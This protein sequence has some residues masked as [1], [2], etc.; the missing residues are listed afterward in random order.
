[1]QKEDEST[2]AKLKLLAKFLSRGR[3]LIISTKGTF[4]EDGKTVT[5]WD[6]QEKQVENPFR[7][8]EQLIGLARSLAV[9][10]G[11]TQVTEH[12]IELLRR[13]VLSSMPVDRSRALSLFTYMKTLTGSVTSSSID[14]NQETARR[15]LEELYELGLLDRG[16]EMGTSGHERNTYSPLP[17]FEDIIRKPVKAL[18]HLA[19][20]ISSTQTSTLPPD[21]SHNLDTN[22][23]MDKNIHKGESGGSLVGDSSSPSKPS[24][25]ELY[26]QHGRL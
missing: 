3:G 19:D 21:G 14:K 23:Y 1:M 16:K 22:I 11:R 12:E 4:E 20:L 13:V 15:L 9:I 2:K 5:Y 10:H 6:T 26:K 24:L 8:L 7:A 25:E 18:D 17:E